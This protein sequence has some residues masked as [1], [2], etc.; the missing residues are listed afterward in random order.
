MLYNLWLS[1]NENKSLAPNTWPELYVI[2]FSISIGN[3]IR[4]RT[5]CDEKIV[6]D[7]EKWTLYVSLVYLEV[8]RC[9]W[10]CLFWIHYWR[11]LL[12][13]LHVSILRKNYMQNVS[14]S[15]KFK[16]WHVKRY[17]KHCMFVLFI[18]VSTSTLKSESSSMQ[19]YSN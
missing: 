13:P 17:L 1:N 18:K 9:C 12:T 5:D 6:F 2:L 16:T 11:V 10:R 3:V 15:I 19:S 14:Y 7:V 8:E 4:Q